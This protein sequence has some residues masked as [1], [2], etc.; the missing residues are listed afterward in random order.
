M[1]KGNMGGEIYTIKNCSANVF[2][3]YCA[4]NEFWEQVKIHLGQPK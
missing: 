2:H 4:S 1:V 3:F